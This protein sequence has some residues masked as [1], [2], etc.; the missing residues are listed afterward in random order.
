MI[1]VLLL[2]LLI[3]AAPPAAAQTFDDLLRQWGIKLTQVE[4]LIEADDKSPDQLKAA[5]ADL[6]ALS[7]ELKVATQKFTTELT[8]LE[9]GLEKLGAAPEEGHSEPRRLAEERTRLNKRIEELTGDVRLI[10]ALL[11]RAESAI[12]VVVNQRRTI[13]T[14]QLQTRGPSILD[15]DVLDRAGEALSRKLSQLGSETT[16]QFERRHVE[17]GRRIR[18]LLGLFVVAGILFLIFRF[19]V[20]A[21]HWLKR[22]LERGETPRN[23]A[24]IAIALTVVRLVLPSTALAVGLGWLANRGF[25][26]SLGITLIGGL[27]IVAAVII[28]AYGLSSAY[29][30]PDAPVLRLS[31]VDNVQARRAHRWIIMLASIVGVDWLLVGQGIKGLGLPFEA[32]VV[33]NTLLLIPGGVMLWLAASLLR[34]ETPAEAEGEEEAV[35]ETSRLYILAV[36]ALRMLARLA[37]VAAPVLAL[38]GFYSASRYVFF[39]TVFSGA[40]VGVAILLFHA[41]HDLVT[42]FAD[43]REVERSAKIEL[44]PIFVGFALTCMAVPALAMIWGATPTDLSS[45][46]ELFKGGV[47]V[48]EIRLSPV[49]VISFFIVFSVGYVITRMLQGV[50]NRKVLPLTG[51]DSGGRD[52]VAAGI[53]YVGIFLAAMIAISTTGLDLS[54]IAIVAGALSVGIGFGLQNIVNNFISGIILLVERPIKAGDWVELT[55]GMGYVKKVNVRSTEVETFDRASLFVPNSELIANSVINWTYS[56]MHGRLI[57]KVGVSYDSDPRHVERVL[58][59]IAEAHPM[60]LKR[61]APYVLFRSFGENWFDFEVRGVLRDVNLIL[62]VQSDIN[63]E[64]ARRFA[65]EGI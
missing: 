16:G 24:S 20:K 57:V 2:V 62:N 41:V 35:E 8:P 46:W 61:P 65:L 34:A 64:I 33:I 30:S 26:G 15:H 42:Q 11:L 6:L 10:D 14:T 63:F 28:G 48:G 45:W 3:A 29:F 21:E 1:R 18:F 5:R 17:S 51:L 7:N 22:G 31:S 40:V 60:L 23:P 13:F 56:N 39:P 55:S 27:G 37:A 32:L 9:A 12:E 19:K 50:L 54:N 43:Q 53:G 4:D 25:F 47:K 52:A 58:L 36:N 59:E 38:L 49:D 44:I